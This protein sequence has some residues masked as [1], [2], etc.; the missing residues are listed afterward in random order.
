MPINSLKMTTTNYGY[1]NSFSSY[2]NKIK[3]DLSKIEQA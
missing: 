3:L 1:S 2:T